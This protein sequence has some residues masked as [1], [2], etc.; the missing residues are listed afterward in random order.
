MKF[1]TSDEWKWDIEVDHERPIP[2]PKHCR[3]PLPDRDH[4]SELYDL[5]T[6]LTEE[7]KQSPY[8]K[9]YYMGQAMPDKDDLAQVEFDTPMDPAKAFLIEDYAANMDV[10]GCCPVRNGYCILPNGIAFATATTTYEGVTAEVMANFIENFNPPKDLYYKVWCPGAHIRHGMGY[11]IEDTGTGMSLIQ[12]TEGLDAEKVGLNVGSGDKNCI[13]LTGANTFCK[14]L[15]NPDGEP[16]YVTELCYYRLVGNAYEERVTFWIGAEFKD[17][18]TVPRLHHGKPV[19]AT[20][21][22]TLARHSLWE[23]TT[24]MRIA[25]DFWKE[26]NE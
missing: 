17:G 2:F 3:L 1:D 23:T 21:A 13:G 16:L 20:F 9:Y 5:T 15:H 25:V 26:C 18:K 6:D 12:F 11:A 24:L 7:E 14:P 19:D 22:Q 4:Y 8:A 10:P